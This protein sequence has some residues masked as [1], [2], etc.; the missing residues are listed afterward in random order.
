M[1]FA[2][3]YGKH[4]YPLGAERFV[5]GRS[6]ACQLCLSDPMAS[7]NHAALSVEDDKV[8]LDDLG[9]RNGV[10]VNKQ[11]VDNSLILTHGDRIRI[12]SEEMTIIERGGRE[13]AETLIQRPTTARLQAFGVLGSLADKAIALGHGEE[14]ERILGRQLDQFLDKAVKGDTLTDEEFDKC[15]LYSMQIGS[16]TKKG[17]WLD[18]I[19]RIHAAGQRLMD[20]EVVNQ[21]YSIAPKM[22]E[23][24]HRH[25]RSYVEALKER[26]AS[27]GPGEKFVYKRIEGLGS[28][29]K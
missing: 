22:S 17:K 1:S 9:S 27:F 11:R 18:Y 13:R 3:R 7:R 16:L 15:V 25:L 29:I 23:A 20:A 6:E 10:F 24:S 2:L 8:R 14:A 5:I 4:D 19:F 21:L 12:G 28:L 26:S